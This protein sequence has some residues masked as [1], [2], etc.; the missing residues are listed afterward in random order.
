V[1]EDRRLYPTEA[2]PQRALV[3]AVDLQ[4]PQRPLVPELAEFVALA[5]AAG[6]K[7]VGEVVQRLAHV[8][9]AT[10]VGSGKAHEIAERAKELNADVL[11][12]FNDRASAPTSRRSCRCR[13]STA[14]C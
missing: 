4:D 10:L 1:N 2:G 5:K 7:V 8:D 12:V 6:V 9:A 14:R 11:F 13:S 3:V